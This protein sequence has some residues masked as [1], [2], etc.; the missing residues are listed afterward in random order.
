ML[1]AWAQAAVLLLP[2]PAVIVANLAERDPHGPFRAASG[3]IL[4]AIPAFALALGGVQVVTDPALRAGGFGLALSGAVALAVQAGPAGL[5]LQRLMPYR[6]SSHV[7]RLALV[8]TV[9]ITGNQVT[10]QL[11]SD[12]LAT[13]AAGAAL[14]RT[15]L[16]LQELP[17]LIAA[18][19]GAGLL[20]RRST[21]A[22]A[23][24]LGLVRPAPWQVAAGL[25]AAAAFVAFGT[26]M[27]R[28]AEVLTPDL[29]RRVG[30]ASGRVFGHLG[31]PAGVMTIAIA[32][33]LCE[34]A[35]FRGALQPRLGLLWPAVV[36]TAVH[37]QY[38]LS[39]DTVAVL[40]LATSLG[41]LRRYTNTTT[42]IVCHVAYNAA[43]GFGLGRLPPQQAIAVAAG[44]VTLLVIAWAAG[45]TFRPAVPPGGG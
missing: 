11:T 31:D 13:T 20:T 4:L 36:F 44:L 1:A 33:G 28:L 37:T 10:A 14:S 35:L 21:R 2:L 18:F 6:A 39:L 17:F 3:A 22:T 15:D 24:R 34:E 26:G 43:V 38:G 41:L 30:A 42:T 9:L 7:H 19:F 25:V 8:L 5:L 12:V 27:D 29:A 16:V 23:V 45:R 32:A 40:V